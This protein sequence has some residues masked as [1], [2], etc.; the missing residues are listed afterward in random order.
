MIR[1]LLFLS[2][3]GVATYGFIA[4][5]T[6]DLTENSANAGQP[7]TQQGNDQK[8]DVGRKRDELPSIPEREVR[9][10]TAPSTVGVGMAISDRGQAIIIPNARVTHRYEQEVS[11]QR[12]GELTVLGLEVPTG[13]KL[14]PKQR[15]EEE[16]GFLAVKTDERTIRSGVKR[17][18]VSGETELNF[19]R[20]WTPLDPL[21]PGELALGIETKLFKKLAVGERVNK[22][23]LI[24]VVTPKIVMDELRKK[25]AE[26]SAA[27]AKREATMKTRDEALKRYESAV[28]SDRRQPGSVSREEIRG[29][30][31][32]YERYISELAEASENIKIKKG[33]VRQAL[34]TLALHEMRAGITG[35]VRE[36][37]KEAKEGVKPQEP[38]L[39]IVDEEHLRA[40]ALV[41]VELARLL[42]K[43]M[44]VLV[45][46][47]RPMAPV[48]PL[49]G[50]LQK[51]NA[52]AVTKGQSPSVVSAS[53]DGRVRVTPILRKKFG[54][55]ERW[56]SGKT[57][58]VLEHFTPV[59]SVACSPVG[60]DHNFCLTGTQDGVA[61]LWFLDKLD[62]S[63]PIRLDSRHDGAINAV[64]F[65]H[66]GKWIATGGED[67]SI[68]I[69]ET[70]TGK[71]K[72]HIRDAGHRGAVSS[73]QFTPKGQ[74]VSVGRDNRMLLWDLNKGSEPSIAQ[75]FED[76]SGQVDELGVH[77]DGKHVLMD[78]DGELR[79]QTLADNNTVSIL[80]NL[81]QG[82]N[83]SKLALFSPDGQTILTG[84]TSDEYVQLWRNP[85]LGDTGRRPAE[86]QRLIWKTG[87]VT[88]AA[89]APQANF[90]ITGTDDNHV[91]VWNLPSA[92]EV[93]EGD[94]NAVIADV[95][96]QVDASG[97]RQI[98]VTLNEKPEGLELGMNSS[99][100]IYPK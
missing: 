61:R 23:D 73:L 31:L 10:T 100:V 46:F 33:D 4:W 52:V 62:K 90:V 96:N 69:F 82:A 45:E 94:P 35:V 14:D 13:T 30:F 21:V 26:F 18:R 95:A 34:T 56:V 27:E 48:L 37:Y 9:V 65:S 38:V 71:L 88:C 42:K 22:G 81:S 55:K 59:R 20:R 70:K 6:G 7:T 24:G 1:S 99:I 29:L 54:N 58:S 3:L 43:D 57:V 12:E 60:A 66:D 67:R 91:L 92:D 15:L 77:P 98:R 97:R 8:V 36:M 80:R 19:W 17:V 16:L 53:E 39:K 49:T 50:H 64:T 85:V 74:L 86:I 32:T 75:W 25:V 79:I 44:P 11:S 87:E 76:R 40:E 47:A 83:F 68:R 28:E 41:P 84:S 93:K 78:K 72:H 89:Y 51:I 2:L 63:R 5:A